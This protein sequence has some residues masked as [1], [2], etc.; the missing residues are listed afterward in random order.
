MG[1]TKTRE[2]EYY[3]LWPGNQGDSGT[4]DTAY[5]EIPRDTPADEIEDE[6][7]EAADKV[8]WRDG[9]IPVAV[10]LY[11]DTP[12]EALAC[13]GC[14]TYEGIRLNVSLGCYEPPEGYSV[15]ERC[16]VCDK[17]AN[18]LGAAGEVATDVREVECGDHHH[19]IGRLAPSLADAVEETDVYAAI[20]LW[21][22]RQGAAG[23][24]EE[25]PT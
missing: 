17:F 20:P 1:T 7:R 24:K 4:W 5:I 2:V 25:K 13:E 9:K 14:V 10:G 16:D 8:E 22:E 6:I 3:R 21:R 23:G 11:C 12:E 15:I 19:V 18:D